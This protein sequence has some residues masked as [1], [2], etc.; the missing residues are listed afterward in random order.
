MDGLGVLAGN[1]VPLL[2]NTVHNPHFSVWNSVDSLT[3]L[4]VYI[5]FPN[6]LPFFVEFAH[7]GLAVIREMSDRNWVW[8]SLD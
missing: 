7:D 3:N 1:W 2:L 5:W 4:G 8:D 6:E